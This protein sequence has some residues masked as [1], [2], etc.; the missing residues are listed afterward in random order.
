MYY[1]LEQQRIRVLFAILSYFSMSLLRTMRRMCTHMY[2]TTTLFM[3]GVRTASALGVCDTSVPLVPALP[4]V[5]S[6]SIPA[7]VNSGSVQ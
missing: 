7:F 2:T 3:V 1:Q 6:S 4:T 5:G